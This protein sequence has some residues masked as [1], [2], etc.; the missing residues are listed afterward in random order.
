MMSKMS[1]KEYLDELRPKYRKAGKQ[2][3][4]QLLSDFCDFTGYHKKYVITL[5]NSL[6][7]KVQAKRHNRIP[8]VYDQ[9]VINALLVIWNAANKICAERLTPYIPEMLEKLIACRELE[10]APE[11]KE[12]LLKV[13]ESTVK[14][15]L[16]T[17]KNRNRIKIGGTTKPGSLL[18]SQIEIRYGRWEEEDPGWCEADT[19]AHCGE[20]MKGDFIFS[21]NIIDICSGWSE[22]EAIW[23]KGDLATTE[24]IDRMRLRLPF[25]LLGIDP[26]N[27]GEFINWSLYRY[28]QKHQI[29][30]TRSRPFHKNDN[31]H[32]EQKN[33]TAIR[34]L[35][36]YSR[37][38]QKEHV[39]LLNDLYQNEWRLYLNFFQPVRKFKKKTKDLTT[40]RIK[41]EYYEAKTPY[42]RLLQ[43]PKTTNEQKVMLKSIYEQL[44]PVKLL[45]EIERKVKLIERSLG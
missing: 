37:L 21:I 16:K 22:Q 19:V 24:G 39:K 4:G 35:V 44:N 33:W 28:C 9:P 12:K 34:Q 38:D 1:R 40:G 10:V 31:A 30:F 5:L 7:G 42:Q 27:G 18:K 15:I 36:G 20:T 17:E 43:H 8:R 13:S 26:D 2:Q 14:R 11:T 41:K 6:P 23:G 32:V 45:S 3:K 29:S 25:P